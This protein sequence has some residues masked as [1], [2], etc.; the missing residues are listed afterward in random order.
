MLYLHLQAGGGGRTYPP[1]RPAA[2]PTAH[3]TWTRRLSPPCSLPQ[4]NGPDWPHGWRCLLGSAP[5][6][7]PLLGHA[8][9]PPSWA[10]SPQGACWPQQPGLAAAHQ[11]LC[12]W[13]TLP[14]RTRR[15]LTVL[16]ANFLVPPC[17]A[18]TARGRPSSPSQRLLGDRVTAPVWMVMGILQP[19]LGECLCP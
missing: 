11:S 14:Q 16:S 2:Q 3:P 9:P 5:F 8:P 19:D 10:W 1:G 17:P 6:L 12:A 15:F 4:D 18:P 7:L 13:G